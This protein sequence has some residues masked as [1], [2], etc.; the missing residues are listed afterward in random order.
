MYAPAYEGPTAFFIILGLVALLFTYCATAVTFPM[1]R[2]ERG[3]RGMPEWMWLHRALVPFILWVASPMARPL[4]PDAWSILGVFTTAVIVSVF[5]A[6]L[7][8][9]YD[10][11]ITYTRSNA[12][13]VAV[14]SLVWGITGP[15]FVLVVAMAAY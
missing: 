13:R 10:V 11:G 6:A 5:L 9:L 14:I 15:L 1:V 4:T 2:M 12:L 8:I 7:S 3:R